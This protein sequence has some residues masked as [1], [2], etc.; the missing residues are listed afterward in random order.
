PATPHPDDRHTA[1]PPPP[2]RHSPPAHHL[3]VPLHHLPPLH[4][5]VIPGDVRTQPLVLPSVD[6][7]ADP[8]PTIRPGTPILRCRI[9]C[10]TPGT[11]PPDR[12]PSERRRVAEKQIALE[13]GLLDRDRIRIRDR[14]IHR[15]R[16]S[17]RIF[18]G[19][20]RGQ[21]HQCT[22]FLIQRRTPAPRTPG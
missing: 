21:R 20:R 14:T 16:K 8:R 18:C 5:R 6:R 13:Q 7:C 12:Q 19:Q 11:L 4:V 9:P 22:R 3:P 2:R 1:H 10:R 17:L 15:C